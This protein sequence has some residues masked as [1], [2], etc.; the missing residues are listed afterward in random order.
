ME[1]L[2]EFLDSEINHNLYRGHVIS[3]NYI[4]LVRNIITF[5]DYKSVVLILKKKK[6]NIYIKIY[7]KNIS[8]KISTE[9]SQCCQKDF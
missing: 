7:I 6:W 5:Y 4:V 8:N 1:V 2:Y 9:T 3:I